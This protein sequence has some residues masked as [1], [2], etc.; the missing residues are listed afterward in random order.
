MLKKKLGSQDLEE[1]SG[2]T[3]LSDI[4]HKAKQALYKAED[5]AMQGLFKVKNVVDILIQ[6]SLVKQIGHKA[7]SIKQ[8]ISA[9]FK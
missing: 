3:S 2:G 5:L 8:K 4:A 7:K 9:I 6:T 1:A